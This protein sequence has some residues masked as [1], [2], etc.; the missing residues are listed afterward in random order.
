MGQVLPWVLPCVR[1]VLLTAGVAGQR[2][3]HLPPPPPLAR[4]SPTHA[5][6]AT[7]CPATQR[8][9]RHVSEPG[10]QGAG[11]V[12]AQKLAGAAGEDDLP[13][14]RPPRGHAGGSGRAGE[15]GVCGEVQLFPGPRPASNEGASCRERTLRAAPLRA[16]ARTC[17]VHALRCGAVRRPS[18]C[19]SA[20]WRSTPPPAASSPRSAFR[21]PS[22]WGPTTRR[23]CRC[24]GDAAPFS[25]VLFWFCG[26][27]F[28]CS[29]GATPPAPS[30]VASRLFCGCLS[31][32][33][34]A[35]PLLCSRGAF[36]LF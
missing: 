20:A 32:L 13:H 16:T 23:C 33:P 19:P 9:P 4:P 17:R 18:A 7:L 1:R 26:G 28:S 25:E 15:P 36:L 27:A 5:P 24:A 2:S 10:G 6:P 14:R 8:A 31:F 34:P 12:H 30:R 35:A 3:Q 11:G 29:R 21:S 22:M